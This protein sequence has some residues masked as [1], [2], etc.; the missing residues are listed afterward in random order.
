M[1]FILRKKGLIPKIA[2][3]IS[4]AK[5]LLGLNPDANEFK[6]AYGSTP[7][8]DNEIA[9]LSRSMLEIIVEMA[10]CIE[11]PEAHLA[12]GRSDATILDQIMD[13][14]NLAISIGNVYFQPNC[15]HF[16]HFVVL[17]LNPGEKFS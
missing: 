12:E 1:V 15:V 14:K 6:I 7:R 11:I 16:A 4:T 2:A 9:V 13:Q 3:K 17:R 8:D 10:S 5:R